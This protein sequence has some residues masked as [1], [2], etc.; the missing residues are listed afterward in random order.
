MILS[1]DQRRF[2]DAYFVT[3]DACRPTSGVCRL[4]APF[5]ILDMYCNYSTVTLQLAAIAVSF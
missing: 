1:Y 5:F 4:V 3:D 2:F